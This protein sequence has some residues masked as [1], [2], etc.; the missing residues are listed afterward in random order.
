MGPHRS[1]ADYKKWRETEQD[2]FEG[3]TQRVVRST[4]FP[5][6]DGWRAQKP[7]LVNW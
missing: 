3:E 2:C 1:S 6:D 5:S 4:V 7:N